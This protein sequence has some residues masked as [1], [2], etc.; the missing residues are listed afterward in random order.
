M[1]AAN[2]VSPA[3]AELQR[4]TARGDTRVTTAF[5]AKVA[6]V[7]TPLIEPN[8]SS[9][10]SVWMTFLWK[11]DSTLRN[12]VLLNAP[13]ADPRPAESKL[14]YI[15]HTD[16]WYRTYG[17]RADVRFAYDLSVN[18]NLIPLWEVTDWSERTST[19][20]LDPLNPKHGGRDGRTI[21]VAEGPGAPPERWVQHRAGVPSG[22]VRKQDFPSSTMGNTRSVWVYTPPGFD[23][24][25]EAFRRAPLIVAFDGGAYVSDVPT[26]TILDNLIA[27]KRIPPTVAVLIGNVGYQ[28]EKDLSMNPAFADFVV[29]EIVPWVRKTYRLQS[30]AK[31][32][33]I[34]G[35]SSGGLGAAFIALRHPEV[36][37]NV[38]SQSGAYFYSP[39]TDSEPEALAR[40]IV[41]L[42]IRPIRFFVEVGSLEVG[43]PVN[44]VAANRHFRDVLLAK[45]YRVSYREFSGGHEYVNW[46]NGFADGI[47]A[48]LGR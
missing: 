44:M 46:R 17:V 40:E 4:S 25:A 6:R 3:I 23:T 12:V 1:R 10:D 21:S 13:I 8:A 28:R 20:Q 14:A 26:P 37:A 11:G 35:S 24:V 41:R 33:V 47:I 16:V 29:N 15:P 22:T 32:T 42:P 31:E 43:P 19:F 39:T 27:A 30:R 18:D 48:L 36:F 45:G 9:A 7:G 5:W 2:P 34:A 38:L